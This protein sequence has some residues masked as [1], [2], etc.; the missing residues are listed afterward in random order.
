M[1]SLMTC[2][3]AHSNTELEIHWNLLQMAPC[4]SRHFVS[5][6]LCSPL[7]PNFGLHHVTYFGQK[8]IST[9]DISKA[10]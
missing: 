10:F 4:E 5:T 1:Y 7:H 2:P 9:R 6:L 8:D 3:K